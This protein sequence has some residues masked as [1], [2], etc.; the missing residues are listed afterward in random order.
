MRV[1]ACLAVVRCLDE[2]PCFLAAEYSYW[3]RDVRTVERWILKEAG[4]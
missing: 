2:M 3:W 1:R 4:D